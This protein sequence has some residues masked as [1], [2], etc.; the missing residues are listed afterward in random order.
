MTRP[1]PDAAL[2]R[3]V[4]WRLLAWSGGTTLAAMFILGSLLYATVAWSLATAGEQQ[5]HDR[6]ADIATGLSAA[7]QPQGP[8]PF[9][10]KVTDALPF[11]GAIGFVVDSASVPGAVIGGPTSGTL[12]FVADI[13]KGSVEGGVPDQLQPLLARRQAIIEA[14]QNGVETIT[15][16]N[17]LG[18]PVRLLVMPITR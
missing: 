4:R 15:T 1:V 13:S 12:A 6:A 3:R 9:T 18:T 11:A 16:A 10:T 8:G 14:A 5:L 2:V 7:P 17:L